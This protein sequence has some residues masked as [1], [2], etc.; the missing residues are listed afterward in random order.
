MLP[1]LTKRGERIDVN[2]M[3]DQ[4]SGHILTESCE[5][6]TTANIITVFKTKLNC[7][8]SNN[9]WPLGLSRGNLYKCIANGLSQ[10]FSF[11]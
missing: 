10:V 4:G 11:N 3:T 1:T 2:V 8:H 6:P 7:I 5:K 9:N